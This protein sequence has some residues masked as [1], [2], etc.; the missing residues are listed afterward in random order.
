MKM[1]TVIP[2]G[3][4]TPDR[5]ETR[6]GT[7]ASFDG[8]PEEKTRELVYDNL[9][10]QRATQAF[11]SSLQIASLQAMREGA[12]GFGPANTTVVVFEELM[13]SKSL[14]LTPNTTSVYNMLWLEIGD[15]PMVL[16][17]PPDVL[18]FV[19]D[20]WFQY[21]LDFG[22]VGPDKGE[23]GKFLIVPEDYEGEIPKGY[24]VARTRCHG[25]WVIWR[26][27]QKNG[28]TRA[29]VEA[30]KSRFRLYPLS[31]QANPPPMKFVNASG[32]AFNTIHRMDFE[33]WNEVHAVL[34]R[35][36]ATGLNPEIRGLLA[37]VGVEKGKPFEPDARMRAILTEAAAVGSVTARALTAF[38]RDKRAYIYDDRI[39]TNPLFER[40]Y[41]FLSNGATMLDGRVY[42]HF[43]ATGITPAMALKLVGKGSQYGIAY[44]D[45]D[46]KPLDGSKTYKFHL[47]PDVPA[48]DFW[49]LTAYDGQTRS[50]L[51]TDQQ[52]PGVDSE[53]ENLN[54]NEDGSFDVFF[55][56]KAPEGQESNWVQTVPNKTFNVILRL[57]GP[58]PSFYDQTWRPDD[59]VR[60]GN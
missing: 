43:Y 10:F 12:L 50:M 46:R 25:H 11:L 49:A 28:S 55:G 18:G 13:D 15:E 8:V 48:S 16:E 23:G 58:L 31:Q 54:E 59:P 19:D 38:P 40:R 45:K 47:P 51:Q 3:I 9:D 52:F 29:A 41:D 17:T 42:M 56:P 37:S 53:K 39:W 22:R 27:F 5:I 21:V 60:V 6:I 33:F 35:E 57:Y 44:V 34:Q 1:T 7:L 36:P 24:F 4:A 26:G 2:E 30:T 20:A 32:K 14:F